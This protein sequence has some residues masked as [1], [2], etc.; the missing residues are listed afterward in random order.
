VFDLISLA[1][2]QTAMAPHLRLDIS[3]DLPGGRAHRGRLIGALARPCGETADVRN[4]RWPTRWAAASRPAG[5]FQA[6]E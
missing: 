6:E 4:R 1:I 2:F 5:S 3:S